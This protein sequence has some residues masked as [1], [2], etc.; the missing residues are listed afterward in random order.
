MRCEPFQRKRLKDSL[1]AVRA[2]TLQSPEDFQDKLHHLLADSGVALVLCPHLPGTYA[3]GAPPSGSV[4]TRLAVIIG[5]VH[6]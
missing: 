2:M 1:K 6:L 3:H 4:V 5:D